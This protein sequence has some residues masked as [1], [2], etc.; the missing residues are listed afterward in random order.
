MLPWQHAALP[1]CGEMRCVPSPVPVEVV[2]LGLQAALSLQLPAIASAR[3]QPRAAR[4]WIGARQLQR[5]CGSSPRLCF[6]GKG[7]SQG[8]TLALLGPSV[9]VRGDLDANRGTM[10]EVGTR[11]SSWHV[12]GCS[13]LVGRRFCLLFPANPHHGSSRRSPCS[14]SASSFSG[15]LL[16]R[17]AAGCQ[18]WSLGSQR[19]PPGAGTAR[20]GPGEGSHH[21]G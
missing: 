14:E 5:V 21:H 13:E 10:A 12:Q 4:C 11:V 6:G 15:A 18:P 20:T 16:I 9:C 17:P 7:C 2:S 8:A 19:H 1:L 3:A